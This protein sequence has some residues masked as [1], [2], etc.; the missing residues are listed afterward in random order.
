MRYQN[1]KRFYKL[2][3]PDGWDFYSGNTINYRENIGR[4]VVCPQFDRD[5]SLCSSAFIHASHDPNQC[6]VGASIPCSA[7]WVRGIPIRKDENKCGF[8]ELYIE[9]ELNPE[10]L[11]KWRYKEA[12]NPIYPFTI[13]PPKI[14]KQ[15]ITLLKDWA[16]VWDS[17]RASVWASVRDS[18]RDSVWNSVWDSVLA[19]VLASVGDLVWDS[20][21]DSVGASVRAYTGYIF[22]PCVKKWK[23]IKHKKGE[24]PFQ[25]A[26]DLWKK[27]LVPS[28]DGKTWRLHGGEEGKVLWEGKIDYPPTR[29][30]EVRDGYRN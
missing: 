21:W 12:C 8:G 16:S 6:F 22:T 9:R 2:A 10:E 1:T 18:V 17:V 7:Y 13:K 20:A 24:Y 26:V 4:V 23:H 27:G 14:T 5:G 30:K 11:F 29:G 15:H 28:F 25:P 3:R 19:S